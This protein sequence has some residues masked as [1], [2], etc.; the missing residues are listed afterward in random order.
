MQKGVDAGGFRLQGNAAYVRQQLG[1][2]D[3]D[4]QLAVFVATYPQ[5]FADVNLGSEET[6]HKLRLLSEVVG[7]SRQ[8]CLTSGISYL[9]GG[10][11][12]IA[13]RYMLALV[14][15]DGLCMTG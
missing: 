11:D 3:G 8:E 13:A 10:L 1:W 12:A 6:Q 2:Q 7:V 14:R 9:K 5:P 4:G 15:L